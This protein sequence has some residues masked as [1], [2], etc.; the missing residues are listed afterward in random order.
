[1]NESMR[2]IYHGVPEMHKTVKLSTIYAYKKT[3]FLNTRGVIGNLIVVQSADSGI[4]K[5][6]LLARLLSDVGSG[7]LTQL[8][9]IYQCGMR[10]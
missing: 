5:C 6:C 1:M 3:N 7:G 4:G 8:T 10:A 2:Q 9:T